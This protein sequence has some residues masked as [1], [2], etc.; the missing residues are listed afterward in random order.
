MQISD[1]LLDNPQT[2]EAVIEVINDRGVIRLLGTVKDIHTKKAAEEI[3]K[4]SPGVISVMNEIVVKG[5]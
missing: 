1:A 2:K 4:D 5:R 3:A